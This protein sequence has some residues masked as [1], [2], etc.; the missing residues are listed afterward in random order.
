[1]NVYVFIYAGKSKTVFGF[2]GEII[3]D[4]CL[5][6]FGFELGENFT[7]MYSLPFF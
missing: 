4:F 6:L 1:M 2:G 3:G 7:R 5:F